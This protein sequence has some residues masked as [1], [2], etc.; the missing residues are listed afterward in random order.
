LQGNKA[1][2]KYTRLLDNDVGGRI[3]LEGN[4]FNGQKILVMK[5]RAHGNMQLFD[6]DGGT[7][8]VV[9][10]YVE[11]ALEC[12][13]NGSTVVGKQNVAGILECKFLK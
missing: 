9:K 8:A 10:N 7:I 11:G 5:N 2:Q 13:A 1:K 4:G 12:G 3:Q 6:N